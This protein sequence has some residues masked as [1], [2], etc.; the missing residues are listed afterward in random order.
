M[1]KIL[2]IGFFPPP[3]SGPTVINQQILSLKR[4]NSIFHLIAINVD[5]GL[6]PKHRASVNFGNLTAG[7][8][9]ILKLCFLI[10][11]HLP[12]IIYF[13]IAQNKIGIIKTFIILLISKIFRR[14]TV[15]HF[16]GANFKNFYS[17]SSPLIQKISRFVLEKVNKIII[18]AKSL[19]QE[20]SDYVSPEKIEVVY[21]ALNTKKFTNSDFESAKST[22]LFLGKVSKAKGALTFLK[23]IKIVQQKFPNIKI[24]LAGTFDTA[25]N[26]LPHLKFHNIEEEVNK[27]ISQ[28][29]RPDNI[30]ML[31]YLD[32]KEKIK[33]FQRAKIF[34]NPTYNDAFGIVNLEAMA[35]GCVVI[36]SSVG[37]IPE[38]VIHNKNGFLV[39][40]GDVKG[41][42]NAIERLLE[43]PENLHKISEFNREDVQKRFNPELMDQRLTHI[44]SKLIDR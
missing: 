12:P 3:L 37:G 21:N 27:L 36:A 7:V 11:K 34:V 15:V 31:G 35:A 14:K 9:L 20:F 10:L 2:F 42:S 18:V 26:T 6:S 25:Q 28:C 43:Q 32:E 19:K 23:T 40:P 5:K 8:I 4:L 38:V 41:F 24:E 13:E 30:R 1:K 39:A 29:P 44:F 22:I 17:N 33:A 16:H